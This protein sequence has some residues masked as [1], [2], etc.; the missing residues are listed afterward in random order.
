MP[1][2]RETAAGPLGHAVAAFSLGKRYRQSVALADISFTLAP[3]EMLAVVGPDGAGKTTL[4]QV[5]AGLLAPTEGTAFI[6]GLDVRTAG[7]GLGE[8]TGYMSEGFTLYGS[9][10]V[11][12]NLSFF[13]DL[14][15]VPGP[16]RERRTRDVLRFSRLDAVLDRHASKLSGGMQKKLALSC[17]LLHEPQVLL[18]DEPTLGVDPL[19]RQEFWRLLQRFLTRGTSIVV[20]TAYLDEAERCQQAL[21]LHRGRALDAGEPSHLRRA[22]ADVLWELRAHP[23]GRARRV[24]EDRYGGARVYMAQR[25]LRVAVPAGTDEQPA[26][27][28]SAQDIVVERSAR[29]EP[30]L[31][32]V[33]V[34]RI[35]AGPGDTGPAAPPVSSPATR[36]QFD[37][38]KAIVADKLTRRFGSFTAL[39]D[40]N[41]TVGP[42]EVFGLL[43]PNGS[44][45]TTL[46]RMLTGLLPPSSGT[47]QVAGYDSARGGPALRQHIGYMSQRFS[48][49]QDLTVGENLD[50]FGGVYGLS[51]RRQL[52][53]K[54]WALAMAGLSGQ[55]RLRTSDLGGGYRQRLA[56]AAALLHEPSVVFLD[57]PTS[58]VDPIAR[59]RF[60][61]LIYAISRDGTTVLFSTHYLDE[62]ERCN[63]LAVLDAGRLVALGSPG[64]L[65]EEASGLLGGNLFSVATSSPVQALELIRDQPWVTHATVYGASVRAALTPG[66][67]P[68]AIAATL[69]AA[70]LE[71]RI[72]PAEPSLEDTFAALLRRP[73]GAP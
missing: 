55:D 42:G 39:E 28:L 52:E 53:R 36:S 72:E 32:D 43:G 56:L 35:A 4:V 47:A 38:A 20:T 37:G 59:R 34:A 7:T 58:G 65:K 5:L 22:Y 69:A 30:T 3:G 12:E 61:D 50:F 41:L 64:E 70:G 18:L 49:Y 2:P 31:E 33:F 48:L 54:D 19:S 10:T 15:G 51:G 67:S 11:A 45:K 25:D 66:A 44:G 14:Y 46:I 27:L 71:A 23:S 9:L 16:E 68:D 6:G 63:R 24:L 29:V 62:A 73:A 60:W 40:V 1:G 17:V 57:E 13:A 21:L 26:E 8:R